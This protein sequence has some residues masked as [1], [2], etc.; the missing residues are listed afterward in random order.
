MASS[1]PREIAERMLGAEVVL[2]WERDVVARAYLELE[3]AASRVVRIAG[4]GY[5]VTADTAWH[6]AWQELAAVVGLLEKQ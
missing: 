6:D 4:S 1:D 2:P 5:G 3:E